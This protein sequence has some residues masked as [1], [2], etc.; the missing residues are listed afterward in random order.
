MTRWLTPEEDRAWRGLVQ[1]MHLLPLALDRQLQHDAGL[2]HSDYMVLAMLS[3]APE[4]RVRMSTLAAWTA[5]SL[6]R[7]SHAVSR[8]E[9]RGWVERTRCAED[10]RGHNATLTDAG[11]AALAEAA[12]GH[13]EEVRRRVF[14]LLDDQQ[15]RA[16]ADVA[17]TLG[18]R[19]ADQVCPTTRS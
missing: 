17:S 9:S 1:V 5:T 12:P 11:F 16:L 15:V 3:E 4:R 19:L 10:G 7:L 6:S 14:D 2:S 18:G 13:V 8:L